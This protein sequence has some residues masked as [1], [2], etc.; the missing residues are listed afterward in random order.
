MTQHSVTLTNL[1]DFV[2]YETEYVDIYDDDGNVI[3][4]EEVIVA[5]PVCAQGDCTFYYA[6]GSTDALGNGPT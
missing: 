5:V 1:D 3:G 4:Q 6:V 2:I